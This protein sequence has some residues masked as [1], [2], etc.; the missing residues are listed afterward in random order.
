MRIAILDING[1]GAIGLEEYKTIFCIWQ[2]PEE[3]ATKSFPL[4]D[5]NGDGTI[6]KE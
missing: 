3:L 6:S 4:L 5:L 2:L 1:D